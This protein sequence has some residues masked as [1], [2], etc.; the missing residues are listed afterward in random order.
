MADDDAKLLA[1]LQRWAA[2]REPAQ[3]ERV[4]SLQ[5]LSGGASQQTWA[6][7][8]CSDAGSVPLVLRRAPPRRP[9]ARAWARASP[10]RRN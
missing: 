6:F 10:P 7:D 5:R 2:R 9:N 4:E 3:R 1:G 8:L